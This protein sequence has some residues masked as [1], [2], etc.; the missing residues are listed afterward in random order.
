MENPGPLR[1]KAIDPTT[2]TPTNLSRA[3]VPPRK[4]SKVVSA[5]EEGVT[6]ARGRGCSICR[7]MVLISVRL[8][9]RVVSS[10]F[11]KNVK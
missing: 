4:T 3:I 5:N 6:P 10:L 9:A 11:K 8:S 2:P 1:G 7:T